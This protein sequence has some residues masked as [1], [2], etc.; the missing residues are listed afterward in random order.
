MKRIK[1]ILFVLLCLLIP[2]VSVNAAGV[3][4]SS[5]SSSVTVG[6]SVYVYINYEG[7]AGKLTVSC[8]NPSVLSS[9]ICGT[10]DWYDG[11]GSPSYRFSANSV[12]SSTI[13]I[14]GEVMNTDGSGKDYAVSRSVTV[15]VKA[16]PV[17]VLSTN[18]NLGSLGIDGGELSPGFSQDVLEYTVEMQPETTKVNLVGS[19][20]DGSASVSGLGER[21]VV[22]GANRL[23]VVV[24]AQNGASKTYVVNVNVKEYNPIEVDIDGQKYTVV[25]KKSQLTAPENY[26][27]TTVKIGE[28][29]INGFYSELTGYTLVSLKDEQGNASLYVYKDKSYTLYNEYEFDK[30]KLYSMEMPAELIPVG[31]E[32]TTIKYNDEE[33][34]AYKMSALSRFALLYG[35][36]VETGETHMYM[37]EEGENTLQIY[38]DELTKSLDEELEQMKFIISVLSGGCVLLFLLCIFFSSGSSKDKKVKKSELD[39]VDDIQVMQLAGS[40]LSKREEKRL[41]KEAQLRQKEDDKKYRIEEKKRIKE[42]AKMLKAELKRDRK[43]NKKNK[44]DKDID[45]DI[46]NIKG[47]E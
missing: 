22:D 21:E 8:S 10:S 25:R 46:R 7:I 3:S 14:S 12:G 9:S 6:G 5:N 27:E 2:N 41:Q 39:S 15:N 18:N 19:V 30:V 24:T 4:I 36:N 13:T 20:A 35:M 1:Y 16:K 32:K 31:Y 26:A 44:K 33:I 45:I 37:Y 29:E 23:E 47:T 17:V 34:V 40:N 11:S 28:D 38:N 43:E 42:E